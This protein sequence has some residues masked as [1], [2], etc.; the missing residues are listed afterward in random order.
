MMQELKDIKD[1]VEVS[2]STLWMLSGL[3]VLTILIIAIALYFY[4]NRR[5]RRKKPTQKELA[6]QKLQSLDYSNPK[7]VVYTF[8]E[9]ARLF[10]D[11]KKRA[12]FEKIVKALEIYKYKK[13]VPALK[14]ESKK[15][16]QAFIKELK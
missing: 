12:H 3:I 5:R 2:D 6:L 10:L 8:E 4:K 15:M 9:S 1:I 14:E 16:M 7:D 13:D 11:E